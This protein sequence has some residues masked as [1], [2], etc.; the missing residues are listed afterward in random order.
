MAYWKGKKLSEEHKIKI[1]LASLGRKP[2]LETRVKHSISKLGIKNP[3]WKGNDK[4]HFSTLHEWVRRNKPKSMFCEMCGKITDKLDASNISGE[5]KRDISDFRWLCRRCHMKSD[6]RLEILH[7]KD[8]YCKCINCGLP[9]LGYRKNQKFCSKR[10]WGIFR[11]RTN[12]GK[13]REGYRR[14]RGKNREEVNR[15]ARESYRKRM[16]RS[17]VD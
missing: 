9:F 13:I 6:G 8:Y 4:I 16:K 14:W 1:G 12:R 11:M 7:R 3:M 2:S 15:K 5:Y 10:C 17:F